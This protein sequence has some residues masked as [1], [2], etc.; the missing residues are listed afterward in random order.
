MTQR[1]L[2]MIVFALFQAWF[3]TSG[4]L[5]S[6][7]AECLIG[8]SRTLCSQLSQHSLDISKAFGLSEKLLSA[9]I[10]QV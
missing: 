8:Q 10:A 1:F 6:S 3:I 7:E 5:S 2:K 9:P 4:L